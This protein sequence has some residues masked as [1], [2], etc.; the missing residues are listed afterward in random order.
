MAK[1]KS[2]RKRN[3]K[4]TVFLLW[5]ILEKGQIGGQGLI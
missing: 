4:M 3:S 1:K 5:I 2:N